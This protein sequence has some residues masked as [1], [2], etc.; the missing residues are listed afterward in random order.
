MALAWKFEDFG[1]IDNRGAQVNQIG[2]AAEVR[3]VAKSVVQIVYEL[4]C[5]RLICSSRGYR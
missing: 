1:V 3:S 5:F 4:F 2:R